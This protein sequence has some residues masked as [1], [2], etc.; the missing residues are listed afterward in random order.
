[1]R[2][3]WTVI[4]GLALCLGVA[5]PARAGIY[6]TNDLSPWPLPASFREFQ[7][8]HGELRAAPV[9]LPNRLSMAALLVT[10]EASP[11]GLTVPGRLLLTLPVALPY[12]ERPTLG[13]RLLNQVT[14]L[15]VKERKGELTLDDRINLAADYLYLAPPN[16]AAP[17]ANKAIRVLTPAVGDRG[18]F[19]VLAN[20]ATAYEMAGIPERA[21]DYRRQ[22]LAAWPQSWPGWSTLQLVWYR[23]LEKLHLHLLQLRTQEAARS[24][25]GPE[26][27]DELFPGVKFVGPKGE[28]E[29][30][31]IALEQMAEIPPDAINLV[32]QLLFWLPNDNRLYWLLA[33]LLNA[34]GDV[35]AAERIFYD[36]VEQRNYKQAREVRQHYQ[37]LVEARPAAQVLAGAMTPA[38]QQLLLW[39]AAPPPGSDLAPGIAPLAQQV[40]WMAAVHY[41]ANRDRK[42]APASAPAAPPPQ[43]WLPNWKDVV[44]GFVAGLIVAPLVIQQW[45]EL[46]RR[47]QAPEPVARG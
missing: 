26:K 1:M 46:R 7:L 3:T 5:L 31:R 16:N 44:I 28:Y 18:N 10:T 4:A 39:A 8:K 12:L 2:G 32:M 19:L 24:P 15:E 21:L 6:S 29:A 30:G 47:R 33:E 17:W 35:L 43:S 22:A 36:L 9:D 45:R 25:R 41:Q 38:V 34:Q 40:G 14:A 13:L 11:A 23:R 37:I 42:E 27:L 20:L